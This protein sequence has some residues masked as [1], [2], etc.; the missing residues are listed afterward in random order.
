MKA[1]K[2]SLSSIKVCVYDSTTGYWA[3]IFWKDYFL[4][5]P[6][7]TN[8][9][10]HKENISA[11]VKHS[12]GSVMKWGCCNGFGCGQVAV[13]NG[14]KWRRKMSELAPSD[15]VHSFC[16]RTAIQ[17]KDICLHSTNMHYAVLIYYKIP[18]KLKSA[19]VPWFNV[20]R[21]CEYKTVLNALYK[22]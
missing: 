21:L 6:C 14:I 13:I 12:G 15:K 5:V 7:K 9:A 19:V 17:T 4:F 3:K 8:L 16:S 1:L 11:M 20:K 2:V 10:F 18:P 22:L